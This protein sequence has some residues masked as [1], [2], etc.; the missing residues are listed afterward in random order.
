MINNN[1]NDACACSQCAP[2]PTQPLAPPP[3]C[4]TPACDEYVES[5]CVISSVDASCTYTYTNSNGDE[6]TVGLTIEDGV[7]TLSD[8]YNQ[9][10]TTA[11][12]FNEDVLAGVLDI[13]KNNTTINNIFEDLVCDVD[14]QD[15]CDGVVSVSQASFTDVTTNSFLIGFIAQPNYNYQIRIEDTSVSPLIYY[16][17]SSGAPP[18]LGVNPATFSINT[19]QFTK[20][21]GTPPVPTPPPT[22]LNPGSTHRIFITAIAQVQGVPVSCSSE[23]WTAITL[24]SSDCD[25]GCNQIQ[26][27]VV[28]TP[29]TDDP[30]SF[31]VIFQAGSTFPTAYLVN[32]YDVTTG[33]VLISDQVQNINNTPVPVGGIYPTTTTTYVYPAII[34]SHEY[35]ITISPICSFIPYCLG[36]EVQG[37]IT[38]GGGGPPACSPPDITSI[39]ITSI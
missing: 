17:W 38:I 21:S 3:T 27:S 22:L 24:P 20:Y 1:H 26:L 5:D 34:D 15:P 37:T 10:T 39:T 8:V 28:Q 30:L 19:T 23:E 18:N 16:T 31:D 35:S 2:V 29:A 6:V 9:L 11:C 12:I 25:P 33:T 14:C 32:I 13:I 4:P 36:L 7:T